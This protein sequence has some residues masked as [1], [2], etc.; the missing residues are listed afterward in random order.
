MLTDIS[1]TELFEAFNALAFIHQ[2]IGFLLG[3]TS[4]IAFDCAYD[5]YRD[6]KYF[7]GQ[8]EEVAE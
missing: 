8:R 3:V 5:F 1:V 4:C 6:W 7:R 2:A